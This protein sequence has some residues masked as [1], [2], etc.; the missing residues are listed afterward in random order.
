MKELHLDIWKVG[1][2]FER[3]ERGITGKE[4][5]KSKVDQL[6]GDDNIRKRVVELKQRATKSVG[7][8]GN[9]DKPLVAMWQR[10]C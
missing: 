4:E 1:L 10:R 9:S 2:K 6:A 5:I 7:E 3:G 8:G